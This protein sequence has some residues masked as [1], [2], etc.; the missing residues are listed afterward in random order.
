MSPHSHA[1]LQAITGAAQVASTVQKRVMVPVLPAGQRP[2]LV[3]FIGV[4]G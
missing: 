1:P 2:V 4:S 3:E